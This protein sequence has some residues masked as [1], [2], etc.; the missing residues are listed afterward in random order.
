MSNSNRTISKTF[1]SN[2]GN[3]VRVIVTDRD[4]CIYKRDPESLKTVSKLS[5]R[6]SNVSYGY[7]IYF[8]QDNNLFMDALMADI[9]KSPI[10]FKTSVPGH[11]YV[12]NALCK[13]SAEIETYVC[14]Q[15]R[16][17]AKTMY[18]EMDLFP[19]TEE[20]FYLSLSK[21]ASPFLRFL[22][23]EV[24]YEHSKNFFA[25]K[26]RGLSFKQISQKY[27]GIGSGKMLKAIW[28]VLFYKK[29]PNENRDINESMIRF[30][31]AFCK[32]AGADYTYQLIEK[33]S[34]HG[35]EVEMYCPQYVN[36]KTI[37]P[38]FTVST[39]KKLVSLLSKD[40]YDTSTILGDTLTML[41]HYDNKDKIPAT[42]RDSYPNGLTINENFNTLKE[43]HD[44]IVVRYNFIKIEENK[45]P[46]IYNPLYLKL[47]GQQLS[48]LK[49]FVPQNT[50]DLVR[51]GI[52]LNICIGSYSKKAAD[53]D[54]L[55]LGVLK[56]DKI[57]YCLEFNVDK[58]R[59]Y[60]TDS[61]DVGI[62]NDKELPLPIFKTVVTA[63][64]SNP[65]NFLQL[66]PA[67][68]VL[69]PE[70][71]Q[72]KGNRNGSPSEDDKTSVIEMLKN[73]SIENRAFL[74]EAGV[75]VSDGCVGF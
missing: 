21:M 56:N 54:T 20:A 43:L 32:H 7:R 45:K 31:G 35:S 44:K 22:P 16:K 10:L 49:I 1:E 8:D 63:W 74:I 27:L 15:L 41:N 61:S 23:K 29:H 65:A 11:F 36:E 28:S 67:E 40:I 51:W 69:V 64:G 13:L 75:S 39:P 18:P 47:D 70:I 42:L 25:I 33:L 48:G 50:S 19:D 68:T 59:Q 14:N 46:I 55:L 52:E 2:A 12:F 37:S 30:L 9:S 26:N 6:E 72:F 24:N 62:K 66:F 57:A 3:I 4:I 58:N 60:W 71:A 73:W 17:L 34:Q 38:L 53:G 5:D